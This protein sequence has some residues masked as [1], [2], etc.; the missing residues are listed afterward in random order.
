ML[1]IAA[2]AAILIAGCGDDDSSTTE[3]TGSNAAETT[4]SKPA[5]QK[6]Q[7]QAGEKSGSGEKTK[8]VIEVPD[9]DPPG[10]LEIEDLTE[11]SGAAAKKGDEVTVHY[12]GVDYDTGE[13]FDASWGGEPLTFQL[14]AGSVIAGWDQGV[15]GMRVGGRRQLTIPPDLAYGP[16]GYPPLIAPNA[17]LVFVVDLLQ[18]N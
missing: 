13:E 1:T 12:A 18:V 16:E 11:G 17:T 3:T 8:P 2:C 15:E 4:A 5:D 14:G 10:S 6:T 7:A 9:E